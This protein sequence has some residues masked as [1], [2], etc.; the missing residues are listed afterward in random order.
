MTLSNNL[1]EEC[2]ACD[3]RIDIFLN[4][5]SA[6]KRLLTLTDAD[7]SQIVVSD[8]HDATLAPASYCEP[9]FRNDEYNEDGSDDGI[10]MGT[11]K[12]PTKYLVVCT[13]THVL[14]S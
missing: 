9:G 4:P 12:I 8:V 2:C 14:K 10:A 13:F 11:N 1:L 3:T 6:S 5:A 7:S